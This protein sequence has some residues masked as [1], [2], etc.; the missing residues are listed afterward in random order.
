[1]FGYASYN[2]SAGR[3]PGRK[4]LV[5]TRTKQKGLEELASDT[6]RIFLGWLNHY[7]SEQTDCSF[8]RFEVRDSVSWEFVVNT[9]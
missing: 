5:L 2:V 7:S 1:M 8:F 3:R 4:L 9:L 6:S